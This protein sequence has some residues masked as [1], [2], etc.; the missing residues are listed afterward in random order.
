VLLRANQVATPA[1]ASTAMV[2]IN[3]SIDR[4]GQ[5][6]V[7]RNA[8]LIVADQPIVFAAE[9]WDREHAEHR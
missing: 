4:N 6:R 5:S 1:I 3:D 8:S 7:P 2:S 9:N